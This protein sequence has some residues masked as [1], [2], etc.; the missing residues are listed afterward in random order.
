MFVMSQRHHSSVEPDIHQAETTPRTPRAPLDAK[1]TV[2][3]R[4]Q[5]AARSRI[6]SVWSGVW[7]AAALAVVLI[8]F[9]VQN[10]R[11][12]RVSFLGFSGTTSLSV[13]LLIAAVGGIVLTLLVGT[14]RITQLRHR[15]RLS[16]RHAA[17][18]DSGRTS[19]HA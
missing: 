4:P 1:D 18:G 10:T 12:T 8:I 13:A 17:R 11:Q 7:A 5:R 9:M 14:A 15:A 2:T 16:L 3:P 6:G 19:R